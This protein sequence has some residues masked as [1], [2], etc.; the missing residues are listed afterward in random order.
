MTTTTTTRLRGMHADA[1]NNRYNAI[2]GLG[3]LKELKDQKRAALRS[4]ECFACCRG[5]EGGGGE[6]E[7]MREYLARC[8]A[9][10]MRTVR[11]LH[12]HR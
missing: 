7:G 5:F 12:L 8:D 1:V 4:R 2:K 6:E 3:R 10:A 11:E 9:E